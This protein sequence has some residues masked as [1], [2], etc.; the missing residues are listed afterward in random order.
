MVS[1]MALRKTES[2]T[3]RSFGGPSGTPVAAGGAVVVVVDDVVVVEEVD[4]VDDVEVEDEEVVVV[5]PVGA[6][7]WAFAFRDPHA[8]PVPTL[9][10]TTAVTRAI[11][12]ALLRIVPAA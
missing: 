11:A 3:P 8:V 1:F 4:E 5:S 12:K 9:T 7:D 6:G 2:P 10:A